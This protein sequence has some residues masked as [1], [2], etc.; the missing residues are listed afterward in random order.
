MKGERPPQP[1][2]AAIW[3]AAQEVGRTDVTEIIEDCINAEPAGSRFYP[4]LWA[5]RITAAL[6]ERGVIEP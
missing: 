3:D 4:E 2:Y 1:H 5:H 6:I